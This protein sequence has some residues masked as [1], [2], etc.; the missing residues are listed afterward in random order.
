LN[1]FVHPGRNK[2]SFVVPNQIVS[3][4]GQQNKRGSKLSQCVYITFEDFCHQVSF[5]LSEGLSSIAIDLIKT[6][7]G[8]VLDLQVFEHQLQ[9]YRMQDHK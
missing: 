1:D 3:C 6:I 9:D 7:T 5:K 4:L 8:G 2:V